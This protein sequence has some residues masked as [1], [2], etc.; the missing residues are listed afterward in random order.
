MLPDTYTP[1]AI[2]RLAAHPPPLDFVPCRIPEMLG[3]NW[4]SHLDF[5]RWK[6]KRYWVLF[7]IGEEAVYTR[8][9]ECLHAKPAED[10]ELDVVAGID[11]W[12]EVLRIWAA[13]CFHKH[14]R[15][16]EHSPRCN[17]DNCPDHPLPDDPALVG[18]V[19]IKIEGGSQ[20]KK[21]RTT[22]ALRA[23][24]TFAQAT[25]SRA[26][27][28][29]KVVRPSS[30]NHRAPPSRTASKGRTARRQSAVHG[31]H[32]TAA[33][34]LTPV[35]NS[36]DDDIDSD[37]APR[38]GAPLFDPDTPPAS[39]A[40]PAPSSVAPSPPTSTTLSSATSLSASTEGPAP[41]STKGKGRDP[42]LPNAVAST[43]SISRAVPRSN[44]IASTST[45]SSAVVP[46][47]TVS[48]AVR[49]DGA[50]Y[51]GVDGSI[52]HQLDDA[53]SAVAH[54]PLHVV[55]GFEAATEFARK[56]AEKWESARR[57]AAAE[58]MQVDN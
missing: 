23:S 22:P 17:V 39:A 27:G 29:I 55:H 37:G 35:P 56:A 28:T 3:D 58:L 33:P 49:R 46:T 57:T 51:C 19:K 4:G 44:T 10:A 30:K 2:E 5:S 21:E 40:T 45:R 53:F 24:S 36:E 8:K 32:R 1:P 38:S 42:Q 25:P 48:G 31:T 14:G 43:S 26:S 34:G 47:T 11:T 41:A 6:N 13:Y 52:N 7:S 54:G 12:V 16:A 18:V 20:V 50:F 9:A 15:C